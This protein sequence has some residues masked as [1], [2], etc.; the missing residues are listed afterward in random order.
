MATEPTGLHHLPSVIAEQ[1]HFVLPA[2]PH[3][4]K[5]TPSER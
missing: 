5:L 2:A 4:L 3:T 1:E